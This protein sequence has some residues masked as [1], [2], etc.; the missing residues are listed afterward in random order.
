MKKLKDQKTAIEKDVS[1]EFLYFSDFLEM[2]MN[3]PGQ[4]GFDLKTMR[5][6]LSILQAIE[7][8]RHKT[9]EFPDDHVQEIKDALKEFTWIKL[10][11]DIVKFHDE[12]ESL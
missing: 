4:R 8:G 10:H 7:K 11:E 1:N 2:V 6:R 3:N 5:T 9:I 12:I